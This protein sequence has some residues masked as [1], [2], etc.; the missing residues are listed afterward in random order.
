M[1]KGVEYS[2][3]AVTFE[4]VRFRRATFLTREKDAQLTIMIQRG[5]MTEIV[6]L[7]LV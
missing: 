5:E 7:F 3:L 2:A 1:M 4:E 6:Q